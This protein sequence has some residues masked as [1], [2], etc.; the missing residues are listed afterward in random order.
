VQWPAASRCLCVGGRGYL[1]QRVEP[2]V[3]VWALHHEGEGGFRARLTARLVRDLRRYRVDLLHVHGLDLLV[4][5]AIAAELAGVRRVVLTQ[6]RPPEGPPRVH[7]SLLRAALAWTDGLSATGQRAAD[8]LA[9]ALGGVEVD[10]VRVIPRGVDTTKYRPPAERERGREAMGVAEGEVVVGTVGR[11]KPGNGV[12]VLI[13]ALGE[14]AGQGRSVRGL[15]VG[16]GEQ[17]AVLRGLV[18]ELGLGRRVALRGFGADLPALLG[19]MDLFVLPRTVQGQSAA[20]LEAMARGL[21]VVVAAGGA[22]DEV[23]WDGENGVLFPPDD[24]RALAFT[25]G[26]LLD[27][28]DARERLGVAARERVVAHHGSEAMVRRTVELYRGVLGPH[29]QVEGTRLWAS[30]FRRGL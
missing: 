30:R 19:T 23:V 18:Q 2:R 13:R 11:L 26:T 3:Q 17:E 12:A 21:P 8:G 7:P 20:L 25:L 1:T 15:V 16:A 22:N 24:P 14:L 10:S 9:A 5:G 4:E 27:D 29:W 6:H 28:A